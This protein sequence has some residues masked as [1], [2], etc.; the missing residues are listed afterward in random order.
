MSTAAQSLPARSDGSTFAYVVLLALGALD[1]A[2]YSIIGPMAPAIVRATGVDP[3]A[4]G[5]LVASFPAGILVGF[6]LAG[7]GIRRGRTHVVLVV[8]LFLLAVGSLGFAMAGGLTA[9]FA[10]RFA[11]GLGSGGVWMGVTFE[12]LQRWPGQEYLC[13]SRIFAAY[14]VGALVGPALGALGGVTAP[15]LA[16]LSFVLLAIPLVLAVGPARGL[17]RTTRIGTSFDSRDS[18][19]RRPESCSRR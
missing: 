8:S 9:Y 1:A 19:S 16:Y 12:T 3:G 5:A 7:S 2:G 11:M 10:S 4:F 18:G 6:V 15:S 13:M 14:S 17:R